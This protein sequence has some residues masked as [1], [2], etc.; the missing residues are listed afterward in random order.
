MNFFNRDLSEDRLTRA[1]RRAMEEV[2]TGRRR[3]LAALAP[4]AGPA[5]VVSVAYIDPGNFA[6][7][8]EAGARYGY[9]LVWV[10][11]LANLVAMLF[12]ALSARLGIVTG[13]SLA[14]VCRQQWPTP[15]VLVMWVISELAAMATDLAEFLGGAIGISLL[16][17]LPV[18][19]GMAITA[20][21]TYGLLLLERR[22]FRR[23]ELVIGG[24]VALIALAYL[25]E[26]F[27]APVRW[28]AVARHMVMPQLPD[29]HAVTVAVG[30]IGATVMPHALFLHSGLFRKRLQPRNEDERRRMLRL[31]NIEVVIA[32]SVAGLV[33]LAMVLMASAAFHA[34]HPDVA[35]IET[36]Y[37]TLVPLLGTAAA[38]WFLVSLIASGISS[39][40]VGTMA[41]QV[42]MQ[43]FVGFQIPMWMRRLVTMLPSFVVIAAGVDPTRALVLSQVALSVALPIP[44]VALLVFTRS[45][46]V[47]G[48]YRCRGATLAAAALAAVVVLGLN[49]ILLLGVLGIS[50]PGMGV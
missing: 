27:L 42:V 10:V 38:V 17:H 24:L 30:I 48:A 44:M 35:R 8:I 2:L 20:V 3:G 14:Q 15:V 21:V 50:L 16:F 43:G 11:L 25:A 36:A 5:V 4:F 1:N 32:L 12:Q 39:S 46:A 19:W 33:N 29:A 26:L 18:L 28:S 45:E 9:A 49:G 7:N 23:L 34:G 40:V 6:T 22:G 47:M 13:L 41:G 37:R 31:S